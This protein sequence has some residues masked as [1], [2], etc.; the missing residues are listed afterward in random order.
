MFL[1]QSRGTFLDISNRTSPQMSTS[2]PLRPPVPSTDSQH[3]LIVRNFTNPSQ[4]LQRI[5]LDECLRSAWL[6][7]DTLEPTKPDGRSILFGFLEKKPKGKL[8]CLFDGCDRAFDKSNTALGHI[9][10]HLEHK[11]FIC[12]AQCQSW[13]W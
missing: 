6:S 9:R 12:R 1:I 3:P 13:P 11:P 8:K 7:G 5:L 2:A 4:S 10:S